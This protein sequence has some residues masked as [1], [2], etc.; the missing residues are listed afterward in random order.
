MELCFSPVTDESELHN[1]DCGNSSI[2][3]LIEN[4][5]LSNLTRQSH[6]YSVTILSHRVGLY[7]LSVASVRLVES[8]STLANSC[9]NDCSFGALMIDYIAV[10]QKL[11]K[12]GIGTEIIMHIIRQAQEIYQSIPIRIII[13]DALREKLGWYLKRGFCVLDSR[14]L[15]QSS[16]TIRVYLD[17]MPAEDMYKLESYVAYYA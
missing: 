17:L 2:N 1:F 11:Q 12:K 7:S 8:D 9:M 15:S 5:F 6:V 16:S 3:A 14:E 4:C 10:E 13:L